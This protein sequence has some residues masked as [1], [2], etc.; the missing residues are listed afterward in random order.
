LNQR[1]NLPLGTRVRCLTRRLGDD[2]HLKEG[3]VYGDRSTGEC[4]W[5]DY[6]VDFPNKPILALN[7]WEVEEVR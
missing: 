6:A 2:L 1:H 5:S 7:W 4:V 3:T